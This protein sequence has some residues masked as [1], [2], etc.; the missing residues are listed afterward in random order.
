MSL[1]NWFPPTVY[2]AE[3]GFVSQ[4]HYFGSIDWK[5]KIPSSFSNVV[6]LFF[7]SNCC[8]HI[9]IHGFNIQ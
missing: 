6:L 2:P 7:H 8:T 1:T 5:I 9:C 3:T 4:P